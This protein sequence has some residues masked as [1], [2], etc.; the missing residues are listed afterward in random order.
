MTEINSRIRYFFYSW[1][2]PKVEMSTEDWQY[3]GLLLLACLWAFGLG[4]LIGFV[5]ASI[6]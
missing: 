2:Q 4:L 3:I 6:I 1:Y 5:W